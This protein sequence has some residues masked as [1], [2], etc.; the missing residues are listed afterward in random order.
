MRCLN[1]AMLEIVALWE[2]GVGNRNKDNEE[3]F[4]FVDREKEHWSLFQHEV[5]ERRMRH[6]KGEKYY[7]RVAI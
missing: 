7:E 1:F 2:S 3:L 4:V 6:I 5:F